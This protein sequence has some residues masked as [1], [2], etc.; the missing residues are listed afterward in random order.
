LQIKPKRLLIMKLQNYNRAAMALNNIGVS[1]MERGK[2]REAVSTL[3]DAVKILKVSIESVKQVTQRA[4]ETA[5]NV[6]DMLEKATS[7]LD[8]S[9]RLGTKDAPIQ[10]VVCSLADAPNCASVAIQEGPTLS[11]AFVILIEDMDLESMSIQSDVKSAIILHNFGV[12]CIC[13]SKTVAKKS[14][15]DKLLGNATKILAAGHVILV[16]RQRLCRD[17]DSCNMTMLLD[18]IV[19]SNLVQLYNGSNDRT[20]A[21]V[22]FDEFAELRSIIHEELTDYFAPLQARAAAAA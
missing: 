16:T 19:L 13:M 15:E 2:Y 14:S 17:E 11:I 10:L 18:A 8:V 3:K 1:L 6:E 20:N 21:V 7:M 5:I 22:H 12:S 9:S 4:T